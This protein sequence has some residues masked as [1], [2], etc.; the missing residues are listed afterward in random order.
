MYPPPSNIGSV[1][2]APSLLSRCRRPAVGWLQLLVIL[3][4]I[5]V[6]ALRTNAIY[7]PDSTG[8]PYWVPLT[9]AD[10]KPSGGPD[11]GN[12]NNSQYPAWYSQ[13]QVA[14]ND[15]SLV[16]WG[17]G[18]SDYYGYPYVIDG[19]MMTFPGQWHPATDGDTDDD[20]I[21]DSIDPYPNDPNNNSCWWPGGVAEF[22]GN[23]YM[24]R[25]Q[26]FAGSSADVNAN[27]ISDAVEAVIGANAPILF[28]WPG[29][30]FLLDG[31]YSWLAPMYFYGY[32]PSDPN[33]D[34]GDRDGDGIPNALDPYPSDYWNNSY[35]WW[36]GGDYFIN[37]LS[38]HFDE[39]WHGGIL[40]DS[41][42]D[43][44]PDEL[45]PYPGEYDN[46][47][48][49]WAGGAV[50][51]D[52]TIQTLPGQYHAA[53]V[54]DSDGDSIPDDLDPYA[55]DS[56][57]RTVAWAGGD[58]IIDGIFVP[59]AAQNVAGTA[60]GNPLDTNSDGIPDTATPFSSDYMDC[61]IWPPVDAN[62][63][64][65]GVSYPMDADNHP[66]YFTS[67]TYYIPWVDTDG[68]G[69]PDIADPYPED[70]YNGNDSD[71][72]GIPDSVEMD[73]RYS[74]A[75]N[76]GNP[77]GLSPGD[78]ADADSPRYVYSTAY[79][80]QTDGISWKQ[81]YDHGWLDLLQDGTIDSDGDGMSDLY[82]VING[83]NPN[84]PNDAVDAPI[85]Y[86]DPNVAVPTMNDFILNIEK[87]REGIPIS[88]VVTDW[89]QYQQITGSSSSSLPQHDFSKSVAENDWDGDGVSNRDEIFFGTDSRDPG[90]FPS[91]EQLID[92]YLA[93]QLS[94]TTIAN[95]YDS[96]FSA[97]DA[98]GD[99]I[100]DGIEHTYGID[101]DNIDTIR[102]IG[103]ET[104]GLTWRQAWEN[105]W[106]DSLMP[107]GCGGDLCGCAHATV[108]DEDPN[109]CITCDCGGEACSC[110]NKSGCGGDASQCT[111]QQTCTCGGDACTCS[112]PSICGGDTS[113]CTSVQSCTC[114]GNAC[115]CAD[116][117]VCGGD[118][119]QCTVQ[120]PPTTLTITT[121]ELPE[122]TFNERYPDEISADV[123]PVQLTAT[124][125][126]LTYGTDT[127]TWS[128]SGLPS[129]LAYNSTTGIISG[130]PTETGDFP[131]QVWVADSASPYPNTDYRE[132]L[133]I[134]I[135]TPPDQPTVAIT[136]SGFHG[137]K[138]I[139]IIP[140]S[141]GNPYEAYEYVAPSESSEGQNLPIAYVK[142]AALKLSLFITVS[143][144]ANQI[145][146]RPLKVSAE[147]PNGMTLPAT[148]MTQDS[149]NSPTYKIL[150]IAVTGGFPQNVY[151][152][153]AGTVETPGA[154]PF[155]IKWHFSYT[156]GNGNDVSIGDKPTDHTV[157]V[158]AGSPLEGALGYETLLNIGCKAAAGKNAN[159]EIVAAIWPV[160]QSRM[161]QKV[162]PGTSCL[163]NQLYYYGGGSDNPGPATAF[164]QTT[165][166]LLK[167]EDGDCEAWANLLKD[168]LALH[169]I[170]V[171]SPP[172]GNAPGLVKLK[173]KISEPI[174]L[175]AWLIGHYGN[176]F[177]IKTVERQLFVNNWSISEPMDATVSSW[178]PKHK[179]GVS[180]QG[181]D[182]PPSV[183]S[184]HQVIKYNGKIYD[185][186]YGQGPFDSL[187]LWE[188]ACLA[189][190]GFYWTGHVGP[191]TID[192]KSITE[193]NLDATEET[194][195]TK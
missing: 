174:T 171:D 84:D 71:G 63:A 27:G 133:I 186:S 51:M 150:S 188:N 82:E 90:I 36:D 45:D 134:L 79:G 102:T 53:D 120:E 109:A 161:V 114:G 141:D 4:W 138:K 9:Y 126:T 145:G 187:K 177:Q 41:D 39:G 11:M 30:E 29:G 95:F 48:A 153:D 136:K 37:G 78:P 67:T 149:P 192:G 43:G 58:F 18:S 62:G 132:D 173:P 142:D 34:A 183:F 24:L 181:N 56:S 144:P 6:P 179:A 66:V 167:L 13:F 22:G 152:W 59:Y 88:T 112:D 52:G 148:E 91:N 98:N 110:G 69:I 65:T 14:V 116:T 92:G 16:W 107:C 54:G 7:V 28:Y 75:M 113:Q 94:A 80:W 103:D 165:G 96:L 89:S 184:V 72:D 101:A 127:Y 131:L 32:D 33:D 156:D 100:P 23:S 121:T 17:G 190:A 182:D 168:V 70:Y 21:P 1:T 5:F 169:G 81:A 129:G 74:R 68:D 143:D 46:N 119:T 155:R 19:S 117:S 125:G 189:G 193:M 105:G 172:G 12:S 77:F 35:Y 83:L 73:S 164:A 122:G 178:N 159:D 76:G 20:G 50:W 26:W 185:P 55:D 42:G 128:I 137:T 118:P 115:E 160:F 3:F 2:R 25:A 44:I 191:M 8:N 151:Y 38:T 97:L 170:L 123:S 64:P 40:A 86:L 87:A 175:F 158:T 10:T 93:G 139:S 130:T 162:Q 157:Y 61:F 154:N 47:T 163:G 111:M 15:S 60:E 49:W 180:G 57:N 176:S 106:L 108:C 140:D 135:K 104:D 85:G 124:G 146:T 166:Q 194:E 147:L 195:E 31:Q 99:G